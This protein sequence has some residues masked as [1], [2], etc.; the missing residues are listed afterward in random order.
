[1]NITTFLESYPHIRLATEADNQMILDFYHEAKM[2][3]DQSKIIYK[4]GDDFFAFLKERSS[5]SLTFL[6]IDQNQKIW[7]IGVA[8]F[9]IGFVSGQKTTVGYLGDLRVKLNRK[10]IREWRNMYAEFIKLSPQMPETNFCQHFQTVLID[11]NKS[12]KNNLA[13]TK[14]PHLHYE[15]LAPYSMI[16]IYGC[17]HFPFPFPFPFQRKEFQ[18]KKANSED[19]PAIIELFSG[20]NNRL[21]AHEWN[22]ELDHRL[23]HWSDF[24][25]HHFLLIYKQGQLVASTCYWN[26]KKNKQIIISQIPKHLKF[27]SPILSLLPFIK[28]KPLPVENEPLDILYLNRFAFS[29]GLTHKDKK[30]LLSTTIKYLFDGPESLIAYADFQSESYLQKNMT[31]IK[32]SMDMGF[33]SV[34]YKSDDN[35]IFS[36]LE[37]SEDQK[38][39]EFDMSTV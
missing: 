27:L 36:P 4:R 28:L 6:L 22:L 32:E 17:I 15:L 1:M 34:H 37:W 31:V 19:L 23:K 29:P 24:N 38:S 21:F 12:S 11:G 13:E 2:E 9:R 35:Y 8:S 18:I 20:D 39:P 7:G 33:Y 14:I 10:L 25:I 5:H 30:V 3:S 16:N 26:A